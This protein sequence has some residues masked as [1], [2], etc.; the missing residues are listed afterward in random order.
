MR[1]SREKLIYERKKRKWN[2]QFVADMVDVSR[3]AYQNYESGARDPALVTV[4]KL[5]DL[6]NLPQRELL[7]RGKR[8]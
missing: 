5:E 8:A 2:Q 4:N 3:R 7:D 6:F 1:G